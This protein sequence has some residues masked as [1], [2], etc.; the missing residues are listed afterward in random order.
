MSETISKGE[1]TRF[2]CLR[3][4]KCCSSGPNVALTAYDICRISEYMG[5]S[6]RDLAGKY[7]YVIIADHI[8]VAV[9]RGI[10]N[11]CVFVNKQGN[12]ASCT[13]Y[14]ARP[15]RCRLFPFIPISPGEASKMEISRICP[16]IGMGESL[17]PPWNDL[18]KYLKEVKDHY[19][20]LF[21]LI[22]VENYDPL[23]ALEVLLDETCKS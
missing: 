4:A 16:G 2:T 23:K 5:S 15:M 9:L 1:K 19:S 13:V 7:F 11:R 3:C 12:V 20:K 22:F 10:S 21:K 6:W 18:E 17:D 8:P 14:P